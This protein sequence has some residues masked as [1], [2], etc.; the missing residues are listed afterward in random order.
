MNMNYNVES[1][2]DSIEQV[3]S[4]HS[5]RQP[6]ALQPGGGQDTDHDT[7]SMTLN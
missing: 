3:S 5:L 4:L 7:E 1:V 2:N 6:Q